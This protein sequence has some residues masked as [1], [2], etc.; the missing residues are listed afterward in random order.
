MRNSCTQN[1]SMPGRTMPDCG[2][3]NDGMSDG[4]SGNFRGNDAYRY[5]DFPVGM[6]YVP[7]Q[8]FKDIY[9]P[10]QSLEAG[11]MFAELDKPFLGRRA[12]RR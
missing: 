11:T 1:C 3:P 5:R 12:L 8:M 4:M 9:E 2:M 10:E 7:W 6:A